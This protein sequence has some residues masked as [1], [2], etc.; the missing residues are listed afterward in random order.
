MVHWNF[1]LAWVAFA[2][3]IALH[4]ADEASHDFLAVYNP[5][6]RAIRAKL[7]LPVP[8]FTPR[9]FIMTLSSAVGLAVLVTPLAF[10]G[11]HW[12]RVAALPLAVLVGIGNG[13]L[14]LGASVLYRRW[15]PGVLTAPL[16]L[17]AGMWLL[18]SC[19]R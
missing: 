14:H 12:V 5:N 15:M 1:G 10:H 18:W 2:L 6:A 8:V 17:V 9:S 19:R 16:L 4:V 7:H 11:V 13:F 3:V